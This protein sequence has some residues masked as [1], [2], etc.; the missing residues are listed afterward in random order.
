MVSPS[1]VKSPGVIDRAGKIN[2]VGCTKT[3]EYWPLFKL[4]INIKFYLELNCFI[5]YKHDIL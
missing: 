2:K 5:V 1:Q 4:Q 3:P